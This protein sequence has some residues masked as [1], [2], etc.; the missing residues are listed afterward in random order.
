MI[1]YYLVFSYQILI[2]YILYK[3]DIL[4]LLFQKEK[5]YINNEAEKIR[6]KIIL[7]IVPSFYFYFKWYKIYFLKRK[8]SILFS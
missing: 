3:I 4:S 7:L 2:N 8:K 5:I 1:P 6:L